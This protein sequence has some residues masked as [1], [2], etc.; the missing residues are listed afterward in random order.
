MPGT[1]RRADHERIRAELDG[2]RQELPGRTA[3]PG[4]NIDVN[5]VADGRL[6]KLR[7]EPLLDLF[8]VARHAYQFGR[9]RSGIGTD[10][11][12]M[13]QEERAVRASRQA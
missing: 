9:R 11:G 13:H 3:L 2:R 5:P 7:S 6:R 10:G 12:D 8:R 1:G 4:V